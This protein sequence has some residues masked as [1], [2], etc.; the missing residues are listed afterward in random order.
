MP[1]FDLTQA[2]LSDRHWLRQQSRKL[3]R[4]KRDGNPTD[5]LEAR[6]TERFQRSSR[7][8]SQRKNNR[9]TPSFDGNLPIHEHHDEIL[10]ALHEHQVIVVAG[11]TGSGKSTQLPKICLDAGFGVAGLIGHTQP[12]R[13][14]ARS[15]AQRIADELNSPLGQ[16]VGYKIRFDDKVNDQSSI[17]LMTD[18][19][20]LA[21]AAGDRFLNQYEVLILDEA[22]ERSLNIDFLLG[23]LYEL[24]KKRP[25][26]RLI[27]TSATIDAER[28]GDH[29]GTTEA[30]APVIQVQGRTYP[31]EVRYRPLETE[32]QHLSI[33]QGITSAVHELSREGDILVFLPTE[34]DIRET[35]KRLKSDPQLRTHEIL[36]LYARLSNAEQNKIF[37]PGKAK[38]IVLATNVAESSLTVPRIHCVVDT[39][40]ARISRFSS[41]LRIQRL[42]IEAV[43]QASADQRKGR[44]GRLGPGICIR[45]YEEADFI[46][47]P[48]FTTPEIRRT[49]LASVILQA[50]VLQMGEVDQIPFLDTPRPET[51]R[52]GY[53]TLFEIGAVDDYRRM[54]DIGRTLARLPVDPRIARMILAGHEENCLREILIICAALEVQDPRVRPIERQ[55]AADQAHERFT[56]ES[57]DFIS[58]LRLWEFVH[59]NRQELSRGKFQKL[60]QQNFLSPAR[61]REWGEVHRQLSQLVRDLGLRQ[62]PIQGPIVENTDA[63][64]VHRALLRGLLSCVAHRTNQHEYT[65]AGGNKFSIWPGSGL[66]RSKPKW[67]MAAEIVETSRRYGRTVA[68][69]DP[70]WLERLGEH[71]AK[72]SYTDP[73]W[74][75]KSQSVMAYENI[76]LFGLPI[77]TRRRVTY[78]H[79]DVETSRQIFIDQGLVAQRMNVG[80]GF[81]QNNARVRKQADKRASQTRKRNLILDDFQIHAFYDARIPEEVYDLA[82]LRRAI[83]QDPSLNDRLSMSVDDLLETDSLDADAYPS[84]LEV[85]TMKLPLSYHFEP[86]SEEDGVTLTIPDSAVSQLHPGH[87][88][89][90]VPGLVEEKLVALIRTL[91]KATRRGLVPAPDTASKV[92]QRLEFLRGDF[93]RE[94]AKQFSEVAGERILPTDFR[95][96]KL[97][98]HLRMRIQVVDD[99]GETATTARSVDELRSHLSANGCEITEDEFGDSHWHRDNLLTWDFGDL[100]DEVR[101][102]RGGIEVAMFP[103]VVEFDDKSVGLRLADSMHW[104]RAAT[105]FGIR[106]LLQQQSRK[107]LRSQVRWLPRW[108]DICLWSATIFD[109]SELEDQ[110]ALLIADVAFLNESV[111]RTQTD[112]EQRIAEKGERI[113]QASQQVATVI[114]NLMKAFHKA[115]LAREQM[116]AKRFEETRQDIDLQLQNLL[117]GSFLS[118]TPFRWLQHFP[119]YLEAV[120]HRISKLPASGESIAQ[121]AELASYWQRVEQT[122]EMAVDVDPIALTEFR[123]MLEEYRVS[124]FAQQLGTAVKISTQRLNKQWQKIHR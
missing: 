45:L 76:T 85:G 93:L 84:E 96:E 87:L 44:C 21:E 83:K 46:D 18:G 62:R 100:P 43:S 41:R 70:A 23:M 114:P 101:V 47:R 40:T 33:Y 81:F 6:I 80:V 17:K 3:S 106:R 66:F 7:Q 67:I 4:L 25:E 121:I 115:R 39:G 2:M 9:P 110:L 52:E 5:A 68:R 64:A 12:R 56:D 34:R 65:G 1:A 10:A 77:V 118:D 120:E 122:D 97:P 91:P 51:I 86:G 14:A 74:H 29:F 104:A 116:P 42:P 112:F 92:A 111:P 99:A 58:F 72:H 109:K 95:L 31:V 69:I 13:I 20:L 60:C 90:L 57:S 107:S 102:K 71:L 32:D 123:W 119:R 26:L 36:P 48:E 30:P 73:H 38:R 8:F 78:G 54:T 103:A 22:H 75:E 50:K 27:I 19:I 113:A 55:Q 124:L 88:E 11:E 89:W 28:F 61:L 108:D 15:V 82:S 35:A 24:L 79:R 53:K 105:R 49:N 98:S 59:T 117:H 63:G 37:R 16:A 94:V